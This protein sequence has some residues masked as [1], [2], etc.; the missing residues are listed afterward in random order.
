MK[1]KRNDYLDDYIEMEETLGDDYEGYEDPYYAKPDKKGKH[2]KKYHKDDYEESYD[3][4]AY[5]EDEYGEEPYDED[6]YDKDSYDEDEY[7]E[8]PY[9]E[10]EYDE[11]PYDE[12]EFDEEPYD[13]DEYDEDACDEDEYDE[14]AC[15]EDDYDD[16]GYDEDDYF[17]AR[18]VRK[19]A[20][21]KKNK[22]AKKPE[23]GPKH[24]VEQTG[25]ARKEADMEDGALFKYITIGLTILLL[26]VIGILLFVLLK[27]K[28]DKD[29]AEEVTPVMEE[30]VQEADLEEPE[31]QDAEQNVTESEALS[32]D[33]GTPTKEETKPQEPGES[34]ENPAENPEE[35]T[36]QP[37]I[38][39]PYAGSGLLTVNPQSMNSNQS[40]GIDVA[41]YQGVIDYNQVAASG[42]QFVMV[43]VGYRDMKTG[44]IEADVNAKYNMQQAQA[45]GLQLGAYFFSSAINEQEAI[46]EA[47]WVADYLSKYSITYPVAFD[48]E[49][50][51]KES[52]R[53]HNLSKEDRT[54]VA[55]AFMNQIYN[56]GYT[57]M[58]YASASELS[59]GV[60]WD[61]AAIEN[62]YRIWV[63]QYMDGEKPSVSCNYAMWQKSNAGSVPG[64]SGKVDINTAYFGYDGTEAPKSDETPEQVQADPEALMKF[65]EVNETVTAK[66]ESNLRD[67]PDQEKGKIIYTLP[68]GETVT[69][70]GISDSGWSRVIYNGQKCYVVSSLVTTDLSFKPTQTESNAEGSPEESGD[71]LKTKF[72]PRNDS[73]TAKIEV[74][75]RT[76]PSVTN[77]D[78]AVVAT[79]HNGEYVTRTGMNLPYG[80][81][82]VEYNGQTLYC[83]TS[84]LTE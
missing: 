83:V 31:S 37:Q 26:V 1:N 23:K 47:N 18:P 50:F 27:N 46:D 81:S 5:D 24:K 48:G 60:S 76:L 61:V 30:L 14:D 72:E 77:P 21:K 69:R 13:E 28:G 63:A 33:E 51:E 8:A 62:T 7:D 82:R 54:K 44:A 79:L 64:V 9:D 2:K 67:I 22:P 42:V 25:K 4:N 53:H 70:T 74:N 73:V 40:K 45:N 56:R 39:N 11:A 80:W 32:G 34:A 3:E 78:S 75:L 16:D 15:G 35:Q 36:E 10:D 55:I 12:D 29:T 71:G 49:G 20:K 68:N 65:T 41:K 43:R 66:D 6:A 19:P 58:F 17:V 38:D 57:P 52:S 84:Y 59:D